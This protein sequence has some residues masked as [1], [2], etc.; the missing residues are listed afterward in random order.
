MLLGLPDTSS[1][2]YGNADKYYRQSVY[3]LYAN[4]DFRVNPELSMNAGVRWEYGAPVTELKN[5]LVNLDT[6]T[7]FATATPVVATNPGSLPTSLVRPDKIG[8]APNVGIAWRPISGSSLLI[9]AGYQINHETSVYMPFATQMATQTGATPATRSLSISNGPN[10]PFNI[11]SPFPSCTSTSSGPT[12]IAQQFAIDPNFRV[13]YV[14]I[15]QLSAQ[16]DL[17]LSLQMLATYQGTKGTRGQQ[18]ILPNTYAYGRDGHVPILPVRLRLPHLQRQFHPRGRG[19]DAAAKAAQRAYRKPDLHLFQIH[20]RR[21]SVWRR[22]R[23]RRQRRRWRRIGNIP[24][25][26]AACPPSI[27]AT[28]STS[29]RSTPPA[30]ASA[31]RRC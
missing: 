1:I 26:S 18:E 22:R 15:W 29:P 13:G 14:Q 9:N 28:C 5:R 6:G 27:S 4:D 10:C 19:P 24:R 23:H 3:D 7:G 21:L 20:R 30:W 8:I 2:S 25:R 11:N 16:R 31:A 12:P 17:P